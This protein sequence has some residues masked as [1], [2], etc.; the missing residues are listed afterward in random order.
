[1]ASYIEKTRFEVIKNAPF[2][3]KHVYAYRCRVVVLE[4]KSITEYT[5][6]VA[7][8][9]YLTD[10][11]SDTYV[12][13]CGNIKENK[14]TFNHFSGGIMFTSGRKPI[15]FKSIGKSVFDLIQTN[16]AKCRNRI[17]LDNGQKPISAIGRLPGSRAL[18]P[19]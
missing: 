13:L 6:L 14:I 16:S 3:S 2:H 19:F 8:D 7:V 9:L 11:D 15:R 5:D 1:M 18:P 4:S 17:R 10:N 12:S